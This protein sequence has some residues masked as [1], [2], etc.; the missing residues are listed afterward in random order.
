MQKSIYSPG[1]RQLQNFLRELRIKKG[2]RQKDLADL[3]GVPQSFVSKYEV[4]ERRLDIL[5][6]RTICNVLG[7]EFVDFARQLERK[8]DEAQ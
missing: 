7:I 2:F 8:I 5:E 3:L 4:G 1:Q 6:I